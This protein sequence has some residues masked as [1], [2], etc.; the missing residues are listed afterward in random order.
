MAALA[1]VVQRGKASTIVKIADTM[2]VAQFDKWRFLPYN[3]E[4]LEVKLL[5]L[6]PE[7][8]KTANSF[9]KDLTGLS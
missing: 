1:D 4:K 5:N 2:A 7:I 8:R 6:E 9:A 3:P